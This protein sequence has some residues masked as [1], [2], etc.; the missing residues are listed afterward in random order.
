MFI[1]K[2]PV[3]EKQIGAAL[4]AML[5]GEKFD[6]NALYTLELLTEIVREPQIKDMLLRLVA[7]R[8]P[9]VRRSVGRSLAQAGYREGLQCLTWC[10][11]GNHPVLKHSQRAENDS[12]ARA[13]S[14]QYLFPFVRMLDNEL[15]QMLVDELADPRGNHHVDLLSAALLELTSAKLEPLLRSKDA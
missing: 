15:V 11:L 7:H 9:A 14:K 1:N 13:V 8:L 5:A 6:M 12:N 10:A 4:S 3:L 2:P